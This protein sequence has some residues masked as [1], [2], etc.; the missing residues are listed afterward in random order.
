[1]HNKVN[2][3]MAKKIATQLSQ[4]QSRFMV[5]PYLQ[6]LFQRTA[7]KGGY[8]AS[9]PAVHNR[10]ARGLRSKLRELTGM[11]TMTPVAAKPAL[12]HS[13]QEK[14][15]TR[16]RMEIQTEH[17]VVM[18]F[19]VL[20]PD[21]HGPFP[22]VICAHGHQS[23]GKESVAGIRSDPAIA[24]QI[25]T[26][27]YDY[28]VQFVRAGAIVFCPD[29]RG[30]G[31][32]LERLDQEAAKTNPLVSSC[33]WIN[34]MAYPLGQTVTG[35]WAWDILALARYI[36]TRE[37]V[38]PDQLA[39][40]GLSGGGLQTLW[41]TAMDDQNLIRAA[42]VS[43]YFYGYRES[44]LVNHGNCS[45]NYVPHLYAHADMGDLGALIA[46]RPLLIET[47]DQDPLNGESG[48]KNVK[49][50][51]KITRKAYTTLRDRGKLSHDVFAGKHRWHG[52]VA[53]PWLMK[54][55]GARSWCDEA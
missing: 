36:V 21:G 35:M 25:R 17:G 50:Q 8:K 29:A 4:S 49:S 30:F 43:G 14:G 44:L 15:Y 9:S 40:A 33:R 42:V 51:L 5:E 34:Q 53:V 41:A 12:T 2:H 16:H 6:Q 39:C 55:L 27:N 19:Y 31:E 10:W 20:T 3:V 48:L 38:L 23:G 46:P 24:Q 1:M 28:G 22:A 45:C 18:P 37:D 26:Y 52:K 54:Q 47:G 7:R 11:D 32:R 13:V